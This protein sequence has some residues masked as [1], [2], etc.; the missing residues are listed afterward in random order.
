MQILVVFILV[1]IVSCVAVLVYPRLHRSHRSRRH[2]ARTTP[3]VNAADQRR[4]HPFQ[5]V[6]VCS[7][8][9]G[10][11]A[12]EQM[13][14]KRFLVKQ[15]PTIPLPGCKAQDC[16]CRYV[17]HHDRREKPRG[18]RLTLQRKGGIYD[19]E[20]LR[21]RREEPGRRKTDWAMA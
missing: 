8:S 11:R 7:V 3:A 10:C 2:A 20:G 13:L 16:K 21:E 18:R 9:G 15:S 5:A 19:R 12:A 14:H 1:V 17:R 6:S 4:F